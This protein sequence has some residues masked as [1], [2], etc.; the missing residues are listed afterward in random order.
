M[1]R[2]PEEVRA[3]AL[4]KAPEALVRDGL[5][6]AVGGPAIH[7]RAAALGVEPGVN[8][9]QQARRMVI[10]HAHN[11]VMEVHLVVVKVMRTSMLLM[12]MTTTMMALVMSLHGLRRCIEA[13]RRLT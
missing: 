4:V 13:P 5:P 11:M 10:T 6:E 12:V 2:N 8:H 9:L 7:G 1:G 3:P